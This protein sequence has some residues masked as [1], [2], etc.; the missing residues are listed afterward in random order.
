MPVEVKDLDGGLG[1][2]IIGREIVLEEEFIEALT[3]LHAQDEEKFKKYLYSL[4][5]L[6]GVSHFDISTPMVQEIADICVRV[7]KL[8]PNAFVAIVADQ[9]FWLKSSL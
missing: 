1:N 9:D 7:M 5:D 4:T 8:N 3:R 6:I 2:L